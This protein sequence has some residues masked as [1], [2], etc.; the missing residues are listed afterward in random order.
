MTVQQ[1]EGEVGRFYVQSRSRPEIVHIVDLMWQ[2]EPWHK[3]HGMCSCEHCM[4]QNALS[5]AHITAVVES[6][7]LRLHL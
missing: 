2:D 4:A 3:P 7:S 5:C 1:I 6:E